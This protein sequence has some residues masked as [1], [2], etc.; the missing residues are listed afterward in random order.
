MAY[1]VKEYY[2]NTYGGKHVEDTK[3]ITFKHSQKAWEHFA[4]SLQEHY[5][6]DFWDDVDWDDDKVWSR[7]YD[8]GGYHIC[9]LYKWPGFDDDVKIGWKYNDKI[10]G[11]RREL[12]D[13]Y[14]QYFKGEVKETDKTFIRGKNDQIAELFIKEFF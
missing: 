11:T 9:I 1:I 12:W 3:Y 5:G 8:E 2:E 14:P 7:H 13:E 6:C 4:Q 10:H